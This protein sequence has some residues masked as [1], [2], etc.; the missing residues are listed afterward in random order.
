MKKY[1]PAVMIATVTILFSSAC[2][3]TSVHSQ[4]HDPAA[5]NEPAGIAA[6]PARAAGPP[7]HPKFESTAL[8]GS[9]TDPSTGLNI[10]NDMWNCPQ[11]AC[12]KQQVWANSS[13][14]WGVVSTMAKG[15]TAVL[16]YPAVQRL[17]GA[18]NQPAP[19]ADASKLVSTFAEAMPTTE[20]TI[21]EA[22]YDIWLN[23]WNTEVM[24][25]V[26]N[27]HQTF[28]Q[29]L[30]G[31]ATFNG[32]QFRIYMDHGVSHGYPSGPFFFVLQKNETS[33]TVD[34]LAVFQWLERAGYLSA[35]K[36][37]LNAIDFGWEICSTNGVPENFSISSYTLSV[38]GIQL[39]AVSHRPAATPVPEHGQR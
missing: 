23:G 2:A 33:G 4:T 7:A 31:T 35:T 27:Q 8:T 30:L 18:N 12:G 9:W 17:F 36:G 28:Y 10:S 13:S 25:W 15:N 16:T 26:D 24:I 6:S 19:L 29:P 38:K 32:Q 14:S 39:P 34:I 1:L 5:I 37:G 22:A 11:A 3:G 20:G 21:G